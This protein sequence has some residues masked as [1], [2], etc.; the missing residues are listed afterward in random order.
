MSENSP[1]ENY[2]QPPAANPL[3][4][5]VVGNASIWINKKYAIKRCFDLSDDLL[6]AKREVASQFF[7]GD[8]S[9]PK[10]R[11][12]IAIIV[13]SFAYQL[14]LGYQGTDYVIIPTGHSDELA[15]SLTECS[16]RWLARGLDLLKELNLVY[17]AYPHF[18]DSKIQLGRV[19]RFKA[20]QELIKYLEDYQLIRLRYPKPSRFEVLSEPY[21]TRIKMPDGT[22]QLIE[23]DPCDE[24]LAWL[25]NRLSQTR[26]TIDNIP[27][28]V[29]KDTFN[30]KDRCSN[31]VI[32]PRQIGRTYSGTHDRGGRFN[33]SGIQTLSKELRSHLRFDGAKTV[34]L[35][36]RSMHLF[37]LYRRA[38]EA[39]EYSRFPNSDPYDIGQRY[40]LDRG[41]IKDCFTICLGEKSRA[42]FQSHTQRKNQMHAGFS[43]RDMNRA[44]EC[45]LEKHPCIETYLFNNFSPTLQKEESDI[46]LQILRFL[47]EESVSVI[48][49]HES[50]IVKKVHRNIL[51]SAMKRCLPGAMIC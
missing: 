28:S 40:D 30:T 9:R 42:S 13:G 2:T 29:L 39:L 7:K 4:D 16:G 33:L 50:F 34:E 23:N 36:Y 44:Y 3:V 11:D 32:K 17:V 6:R 21:Q 20:S 19:A 5:N 22:Y 48:P 41:Q 51:R 31:V 49:V 45:L 26:I 46:A 15:Q 37:L 43:A 38:G 10:L 27:Y 24:V 12:A 25:A 1:S 14:S 18:F 8:S 35:D 47:M